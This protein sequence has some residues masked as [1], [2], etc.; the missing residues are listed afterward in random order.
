MPAHALE[1]LRFQC[2]PGCTNCCDVQGF[3]YLTETDLE[4]A[5]AFTGMTKAAFENR[6]VYRTKN[7][8]RLRKPRHSQ[9]HFL[10][11][12]GCS[13]HPAK[14]TQCRLFPFW[15][16]LVENR[17]EWSKTAGHCPGIGKGELIQIG[18]AMEEAEGMRRAYPA[19]YS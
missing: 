11:E 6:Y 4:Q 12:A 9:C 13:I 8:L 18:A 14:P 3:V 7:F 16:E 17:R 1:G 5:A 19:M 10:T 15:P 2:Q